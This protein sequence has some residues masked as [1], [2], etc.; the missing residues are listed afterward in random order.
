M[1]QNDGNLLI[2]NARLI[3]RNFAGKEQQYNSAGDRNFCVLLE[4]ELAAQMRKDGWN[5][6]E[7]K[8]REEGDEPQAYVQVTVNYGKGR[9][10]RCV[11]VSSRGRSDL[12]PDE[13]EI[14]DWAD[15]KQADII[16]RPYHWDVNGNQGIKAY[17]KTAFI[18][19]NEDQLELK[20]AELQDADK[21]EELLS[22]GVND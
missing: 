17:L 12:G 4:P 19:I 22:G 20:Y 7:L 15:I 6:K 8:A 14:F 2:E 1:A 11:L 10:P 21:D 18:T 9:P 16:L 5:V 3:F 13:V